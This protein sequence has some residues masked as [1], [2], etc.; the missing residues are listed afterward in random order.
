M[1]ILSALIL[2]ATLLSSCTNNY[3]KADGTGL[4]SAKHLYNVTAEDWGMNEAI[5][6]ARRTIGQFD[7][8]FARQ[9]STSS[10]FAVKKRYPTPDGSGEHM[11]IAVMSIEKN[12]YRGVVNNDA[13][14]TLLV[15]YGDTVMVDKSEITDWMYVDNKFLQ[16][17]Y[18]IREMRRELTPAERSSMDSTLP[19]KIKE[20]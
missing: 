19:F 3:S 14:Q 4:D 7:T 6:T 1:K 18:T 16:G 20:P 10:D 13:E 8:A 15:K 2:S 12:R 11:W 5:A 9:D 17:G